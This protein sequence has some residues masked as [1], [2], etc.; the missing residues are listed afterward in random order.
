MQSPRSLHRADFKAK[1]YRLKPDVKMLALCDDLKSLEKHLKECK[2]AST[3]SRPVVSVIVPTYNRPAMLKGAMQSILDQ[4]FQDFEI[5]VINDAGIDAAAVV[6]GFGSAKILYLQHAANKGLAAARNTGINAAKGK[7]IAYLDDD[8]RYYPDH[9]ETLVTHLETTEYQVAYTEAYRACQQWQGHTYEIVKRDVPYSR[10]CDS[11]DILIDNCTPV[12]CV[13]HQRICLEKTGLFDESLRRLEDWDMW[14]RMSQHYAFFHIRKLTCEF[15]H[16][17]DEST[18][19]SGNPM[20]F[21]ASYR[22]V[23]KKYQQL[24]ENKPRII[25]DQKGVEWNLL[26]AGWEYIEQQVTPLLI[27]ASAP[28]AGQ[29]LQLQSL[30]AKGITDRQVAAA[31][32]RLTAMAVVDDDSRAAAFLREALQ[33]DSEYLPA[34]LE[35]IS[36]LLR[37]RALDEAAEH[38][39]LLLAMKPGDADLSSALADILMAKGA[40]AGNGHRIQDDQTWRSLTQIG[41]PATTLQPVVV[42][43]EVGLVTIV[44]L[45]FNQLWCTKE[46]VESIQKYTPEPHEIIFVDNGSIDGTVA[47]LKE[48]VR[49]NNGYRLIDN[50]RNMGFA[51]GCNQGIKASQGEYILLLNNDVVVT[52]GWLEGMLECLQRKQHAGIVGPMTNSASGVQVVADIG[53]SSLQELP[54]WA[55]DFRKNNRY[56]IIPLR[57]IVGF[58]MLFKRELTAKIGLLEESFGPGNYEDD[59]YCL[60]AELAGYHNYVVGDVFVHHEGG[61]TFSGNRMDRALENRKNRAIFKQKWEP[62]QLEESIL[63]QWLVLNAIEEAE[64]LIQQGETASAIDKLLNNAIKVDPLYA[65]SYSKLIE[66]LISAGR[67]EDALQVL[68][69]MPATVDRAVICE[70]EAVCLAAMGNDE[71]AIHAAGQAQGRPRVMVVLGTLAARRGGLVEAESLMRRAI[72]TDPSCGGAWLSLGILLWEKGDQEGAYQAIRSAVVVDPLNN[73]TVKILR[74]IA[75]RNRYQADALQ[76]I[77]SAAQLYPDSRNLWRN[78]A[79]QLVQCNREREALEASEGFLAKFG[80]DEELLSMALQLRRHLGMHDHLAEAGTQSIS[81]CMIVKDEEKFLPTC[82]ASLKPVVD[83]II[84]VDTGST[85][86]TVDIA[87]VFGARVIDFP[88]TGN[89]SDARNF[90]LATARGGWILVMDADEVLSLQDH[91]LLRQAVRS[92][93][94]CK[95]CWSVMTRNYT[96]LHPEGW[97]ANDGSYICEERAEGWHPSAKIR[98]FPND[99][100]LRFEGEVHEMIEQTAQR[101]GYQM[102]EVPFVVHH[103]GGLADTAAGDRKKKEA[104]FELGKQKLAEHPT[105]L[106]AIGELAVQAAELELYDEAI[107]LW[108]RFLELA[109]DAAVALFNKGFALMR[110]NHFAEALD[111]TRRTLEIEPYHKEA[112]FN[113]GVCAIYVGDPHKAVNWLELILQKHH[114]HPPLLAVLT[115]LLLVSGQREKAI[116]TYSE[117]KTLNYAITDFAKARAE[118]LIKLGKDDMARRLLDE[119]V[120]IGMDL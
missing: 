86:R 62:S 51:G 32:A 44:I 96:R 95:V 102:R 115:L 91:E 50:G 61:A 76:I 31:V 98:L 60:R 9:L 81:L 45:T 20:H 105:D 49:N 101:A 40:D 106:S 33:H 57:R 100:Q 111:V 18:M 87:T 79:E 104:Y 5:I 92:C 22:K 107:G 36:R 23:C 16:R 80:V 58:C 118:V 48:Q 84:V 59:D 90:S 71:S 117:L 73:E 72:D 108:N 6:A 83:E 11:D 19:S 70:I 1:A 7:Y 37:I 52:S 64:S 47:W 15:S 77:S 14:I 66:I 24:A 41:Q 54:A 89:F 17:L 12:L 13:M 30:H 103:Y 27:P 42:A 120:A 75:E 65:D 97:V 29:S 53:Y 67:Y 82:L 2:T 63:R 112:A 119:C 94:Q 39:E 8:D 55:M 21:W 28:V 38:I 10:D 110:L 74:E 43:G 116:F 26:C 4:T 114:G 93:E 3:L 85:D 69:E 25:R 56:R 88:W 113:Y 78:H 35:L 46:C 99:P 68:P 109:P 34:R